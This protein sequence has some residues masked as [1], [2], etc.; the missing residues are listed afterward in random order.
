MTTIAAMTCNVN[1]NVTYQAG[2]AASKLRNLSSV[3]WLVLKNA[4]GGGGNVT[5]GAGVTEFSGAILAEETVR[6]GSTGGVDVPLTIYGPVVAKAFD[7]QRKYA[8]AGHGSERVIFDSRAVLNPPP[9]LVDF[10]KSLP[11]ISK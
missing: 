4:G 1:A 9:G 7:F 6:T 2:T 3:G 5:F 8:N 11:T 10:A